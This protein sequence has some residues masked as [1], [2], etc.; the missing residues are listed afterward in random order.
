M[1]PVAI[2]FTVKGHTTLR[3]IIYLFQFLLCLSQVILA[4]CHLWNR[5]KQ[6]QTITDLATIRRRHIS[7]HRLSN[8]PS[9]LMLNKLTN[10]GLFLLDQ[11]HL[12][13]PVLQWQRPPCCPPPGNHRFPTLPIAC[14]VRRNQV[15]TAAHHHHQPP[16]MRNNYRVSQRRTCPDQDAQMAPRNGRW[17]CSRAALPL[18]GLARRPRH[19]LGRTHLGTN[20]AMGTTAAATTRWMTLRLPH[21]CPAVIALLDIT[22][23]PTKAITTTMKH[24]T[25]RTYMVKK[26][27]IILINICHGIQIWRGASV[28]IMVRTPPTLC[29]PD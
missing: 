24:Q 16:G 14:P 25:S 20:A 1:L 19:Q 17:Q 28:T 23:E 27:I 6:Q 10:H 4:Y 15:P 8:Q 12:W 5:L 7:L 18:W 21:L 11:P 29:N 3:I 2:A 9:P 13:C 22:H 26:S